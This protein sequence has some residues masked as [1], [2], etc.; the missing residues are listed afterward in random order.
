MSKQNPNNN[1]NNSVNIDVSGLVNTDGD[2]TMLEISVRNILIAA[3]VGALTFFG[4]GYLAGKAF[5]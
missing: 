2:T 4:V 3:G 1:P 5:R